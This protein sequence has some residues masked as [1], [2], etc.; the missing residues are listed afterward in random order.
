M[1]K[2]MFLFVALLFMGSSFASVSPVESPKNAKTIMIPVGST[3]KSISLMDLSKISIK[4]YEQMSGR[5]LGL[6]DRMGF[7]KA[8][9]KLR[10]SIAEDGSLKGKLAKRASGEGFSFGGFALGFFLGL[11]G[12][13]VAYVAFSDEGKSNRVK[14]AWIGLAA[15]VVLAIVLVV[16]VFNKV[17]SSL[18]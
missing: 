1:R 9:K 8:Q 18:N 14:W 16:V 17:K 6:F 7:K 10:H 4:D 12:V 5:H 13:L 3:G 2:I 11:I 15:S